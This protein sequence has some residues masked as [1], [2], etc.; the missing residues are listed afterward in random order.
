M[1]SVGDMLEPR[2][3]LD[4]IDWAVTIELVGETVKLKYRAIGLV[5]VDLREQ[6]ATGSLVIS[7]FSMV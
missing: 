4:T 1:V 2:S 6:Y 5:V 7:R 3:G